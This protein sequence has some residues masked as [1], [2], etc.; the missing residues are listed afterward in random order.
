[1][2]RALLIGLG[3]LVALALWA[4][5][6]LAATLY[7]WGRTPLAPRGDAAA[8]AEALAQ[9][10]KQ[11]RTG[12]A[13]FVLLDHGRVT[14]S[15]GVSIGA[16][17]N[18]DT[19]FQVASLSKWITAW[20]VM[21]L[22]ED[23]KLDLDAPVSR[24]LTRWSLP[25]SAFDNDGVTVR[26]LLSHTAGLDDGLGYGGFAPGDT[27]QTLEQSLTQASDAS[28]GAPGA[29]RVG[30]EPGARWDYSGGGYTL[31]QLLIEEVSGEPF[32]DYMSRAVLVPLG[33]SR[34]TFVLAPDTDNVAVFYD[35]DGTIATHY[36]FT[37]LAAASLYTSANDLSRLLQAHVAGANGEPPGRGVL[38][39]ET[40]A[41]MREPSAQQFGLDIWGLG[42]ILYAPMPGGGFLIGH[43][44]SNG[45]AINTAARVDPATGDAIVVLETGAPLLA[46]QL[47]GE[48]T[49]WKAGAIDLLDFQA[50]A[51]RML[52]IIVAGWG[53]IVVVAALLLWAPWRRRARSAP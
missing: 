33:M 18:G 7:G 34:S 16:P 35:A 28:P 40:L 11:H 21:T 12:N 27:P 36:A 37:A 45:P 48:W 47:G 26:R 1:M 6:V 39:P 17:V 22:V 15:G 31:L 29:V 41:Q 4:G 30:A 13:V 38:K 49:F 52:T 24:Y 2:R 50:G 53:A 5:G 23:G 44:G 43:D 32:N 25:A 19:L 14:A 46:T 42:V 8:F 3:A 10:V 51:R 9:R 20:G